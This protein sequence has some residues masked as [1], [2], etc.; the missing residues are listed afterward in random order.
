MVSPL[1]MGLAMIASTSCAYSSGLPRR[2]GTGTLAPAEAPADADAGAVE[3][4]PR[5]PMRLARLGHSR[6]GAGPVG[7]VAS[8][9]GPTDLCG[10]FAGAVLVDVEHRDLG[11]VP[12]EGARRGGAEAGAAPGDDGRVSLDDHQFLLCVRPI[13]SK[14][15]P[16]L[17]SGS[18]WIVAVG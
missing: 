3:E 18:A 10:D 2:C 14:S 15:F 7:N 1:I 12:G 6:L 13:H 9:R 17:G 11:A 5:R 4:D 8:D 16:L